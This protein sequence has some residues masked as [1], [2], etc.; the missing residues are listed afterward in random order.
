MGV[1]TSW[2]ERV[3]SLTSFFM[4][5]MWEIHS[6]SS[7]RPSAQLS[8]HHLTRL[9][10]WCLR[11]LLG[12]QLNLLIP[13]LD[14]TSLQFCIMPVI[15]INYHSF[16]LVSMKCFKLFIVVFSSVSK[17]G[18]FLVHQCCCLRTWTTIQW[19]REGWSVCGFYSVHFLHSK[20]TFDP[21]LPQP[22]SQNQLAD[23]AGPEKKQNIALVELCKD[24]WKV[25]DKPPL[26]L[27]AFSGERYATVVNIFVYLTSPQHYRLSRATF[28]MLQSVVT[29]YSSKGC[30]TDSSADNCR[31]SCLPV[32]H[33][34]STFIMFSFTQIKM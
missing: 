4:S 11:F 23:C 18:F 7:P 12:F 5:M 6:D 26:L 17:L 24:G 9:V 34:H 8:V 13:L 29:F 33:K 25:K 22:V 10:L 27:W 3:I 2:L 15:T 16:T 14:K 32:L 21:T 28:F 20:L 31:L 1:W 30:Q 19:N